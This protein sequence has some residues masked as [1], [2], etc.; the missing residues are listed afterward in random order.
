MGLKSLLYVGL[1]F[2]F[3]LVVSP[4]MAEAKKPRHKSSYS[5]EGWA[6]SGTSSKKK[7]S[8]ASVKKSKTEKKKK[9]KK[10]SKKKKHY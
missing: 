9:D 5:S 1:A 4:N 2:F 8:V 6:S 3:A 10:K 7:R